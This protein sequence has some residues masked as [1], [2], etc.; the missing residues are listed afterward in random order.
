MFEPIGTRVMLSTPPAITSSCVSLITACTAKWIACWPE[1]H[2]RSTLVAGHALRQRDDS[3]Q[4]RADVARLRAALHDAT[5][6]HVVDR[7]RIDAGARDQRIEHLAAE[8]GRMDRRQTSLVTTARGSN[9]ACDVCCC[10]GGLGRTVDG[11]RPDIKPR[12]HTR[13]R[14]CGATL[15]VASLQDPRQVATS[16]AGHR[17]LHDGGTHK[18]GRAMNRVG[19]DT[20]QVYDCA[21]VRTVA[22]CRAMDK[23]AAEWSASARRTSRSAHATKTRAKTKTAARMQR[24]TAAARRT[25]LY[26]RQSAPRQA[27]RTEEA[28]AKDTLHASARTRPPATAIGFAAPRPSARRRSL[29]RRA[30][31]DFTM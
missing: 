18:G 31:S 6:D 11:G 17:S 15:P 30:G 21:R 27:Q 8:I 1:P 25:P 12:L 13:D 9:R 14:N 10:H 5:E 23:T 3:T 26:E 4:L 22:A 24:A 28:A 20:A 16:G 7:R 29:C 2:W 19:L